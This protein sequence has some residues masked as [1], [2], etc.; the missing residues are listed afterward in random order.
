MCTFAH[1]E[2]E[3]RTKNENTFLVPNSSS[4]GNNFNYSQPQVFMNPNQ[5]YG[6]GQ[7]M[8]F[9]QEW[10]P[11]MSQQMFAYQNYPFQ[12]GE[13]MMVNPNNINLNSS[14]GTSQGSSQG[15][16]V[17]Q[18]QP[19]MGYQMQGNFG[20]GGQMQGQGSIPNENYMKNMQK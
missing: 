9:P 18:V 19:Y 13:N 17:G 15:Y 2:S 11:E 7:G 10:S 1:G 3:L 6:F 20:I 14:S 5:M 12:G 4:Q 16:G 8:N